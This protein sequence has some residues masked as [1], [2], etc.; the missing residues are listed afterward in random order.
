MIAADSASTQSLTAADGHTDHHL[1]SV[2]A[3][4]P[5]RPNSKWLT[6]ESSVFIRNISSHK[7]YPSN[8]YTYVHTMTR[9]NAH[10]SD[11]YLRTGW[12]GLQK[13]QFFLN[14]RCHEVSSLS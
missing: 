2:A 13:S 3:M 1:P 12:Y 5:S 14:E 6:I 10:L 8:H 11:S 4:P 7:L 9:S